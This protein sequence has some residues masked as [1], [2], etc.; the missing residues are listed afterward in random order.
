MKILLA[1]AETKISGGV[2]KTFCKDNFIFPELFEKRELILD[3][4]EKYVQQLDVEDIKKWFGLKGEKEVRKYKE[5]LKN[6]PSLKAIERYTG[7]VFD[8]L[9]Y[10]TLDKQ[11]QNYID[12]NVYLFSNLFGPLKADD[13]IPDYRYKQGA[14]LPD[15][16]VERFYRDNFTTALDD[17][18]GNEIFDIRATHYEKFYQIKKAEVLTFKFIKDGKV[19]SHWAKYYRGLLLRMLAKNDITSFASFMQTSIDGLK[20]IEIQEKNN[21]KLLIMQIV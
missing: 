10:N 12:Q 6:K 17:E 4:Y 9:D 1:P 13:F 14:K 3:T 7:V 19:V 16:N 5:L 2:E 20:L 21:V 11:E 18:L 8:A 15:I